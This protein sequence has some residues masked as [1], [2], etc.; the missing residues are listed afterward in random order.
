M[1]VKVRIVGNL[2][3]MIKGLH[4]Q[5][6]ALPLETNA[7]LNDVFLKLHIKK[8]LMAFADGKRLSADT[9]LYD[10]MDITI[11]SPAMGG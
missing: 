1:L 6:D 5:Y 11:I 7:R 8:E 10:G 9:L 4:K 3:Y 2:P